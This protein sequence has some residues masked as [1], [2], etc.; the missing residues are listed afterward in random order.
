MNVY[1]HKDD[2]MSNNEEIRTFLLMVWRV[3]IIILNTSITITMRK[4][5]EWLVTDGEKEKGNRDHSWHETPITASTWEEIWP[6]LRDI[7]INGKWGRSVH[8]LINSAP[9]HHYLKILQN[10]Q[11][12]SWYH[13]LIMYYFHSLRNIYYQDVSKGHPGTFHQDV[14]QSFYFIFLPDICALHR[15]ILTVNSWYW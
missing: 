5:L 7:D 10:S 13:A 15:H 1:P 2:S 3:I 4:L 8:W 9:Y 12:W 11:I 14:L 6:I